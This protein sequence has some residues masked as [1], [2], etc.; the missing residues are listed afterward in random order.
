[1]KHSFRLAA[2][3]SWLK[4]NR[5]LLIFFA[6]YLIIT[7][8]ALHF[9]ENW[10]DE[11]QAWLT[12]RDCS[13]SELVA[14]MKFE[15]HFLPWYLII[16]PFAKLGLPFE[17]INYISWTIA[18]ISA[19]LM[20]KHLPLKLYQRIILIF[21]LPMIYFFPVVARCYCLLPLAVILLI[22]FHEERYQKPFCYTLA[23]SL[24]ALV[25][26]HCLM[27][28]L[29]VGIDF[30]WGWFKQRKKFSK[31]KNRRLFFATLV[32]IFLVG[33]SCLL[34]LG[35]FT[36]S[37]GFSV[38][39]SDADVLHA[40]MNGVA[41]NLTLY[42]TFLPPIVGFFIFAFVFSLLALLRWQVF[43][44]L[45]PAVLWQY[46]VQSLVFGI[47]LPQRMFLP[48]F[49]LLFFLCTIPAKAQSTLTL[50]E[51]ALLSILLVA[52][53]CFSG[54]LV[55]YILTTVFIALAFTPSFVRLLKLPADIKKYRRL[56]TPL[57]VVFAFISVIDGGIIL[58][59]DFNYTY[60]DSRATAEF[61]KSKLLSDNS[62]VLFT[63][64]VQTENLYTAVIAYLD[65][66]APPFY[67]LYLKDY[68][69]YGK[70]TYTIEDRKDYEPDF[71][72]CAREHYEHCYYIYPFN[73]NAESD[74]KKMFET[75]DAPQIDKLV[76]SGK[77]K[78]VYNSTDS[79][80]GWDL[81]AYEHFRIYEVML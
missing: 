2:L 31:K 37:S 12:A 46:L 67:D 16:F 17:T 1:M 81:A 75:D 74:S 5:T 65:T 63:S 50:R 34:L 21:T 48:F 59:N 49:F 4:T 73:P 38:A 26:T 41:D 30:V 10:E 57:F 36:K 68:Y 47:A 13:L 20:L 22:M 35:S 6:L 66:A 69:T 56:V 8:I 18:A 25:H 43:A 39:V 61:I 70:L 42:A 80:D 62:K 45:S 9:H 23:L 40:L 64:D 28:A 79:D 44:R 71:D 52:T 19:W 58:Y 24:A 3:K 15:G 14:R 76:T 33:A 72:F 7:F 53:V 77:L 32:P 78:L 51:R 27:F 29:I 60:T 54:S 11:A 55:F